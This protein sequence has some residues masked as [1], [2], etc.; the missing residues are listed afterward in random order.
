[1]IRTKASCLVVV[2]T[3]LFAAV[4]C[5]SEQA[6][7][8]LDEGFQEQFDRKA[9]KM[10][11]VFKKLDAAFTASGERSLSQLQTFQNT[12]V[13]KY[14]Q[15]HQPKELVFFTEDAKVVKR[16]ERAVAA[17]KGAPVLKGA[18]PAEITSDFLGEQT[19]ERR[20]L[21]LLWKLSLDGS[22]VRYA[23]LNDGLLYIVTKRNMIFCIN[24]DTGLTQ[25]VYDLKSRPDGAPGFN[26]L[27]VII[28]AGDTIRIIEKATGMD[29][30]R[31]ETDVQ[32]SSRPY[33]GERTYAF[34]CW[35][36]DVCGFSIGDRFP[37]W[38]LKT[39]NH[40]F[41]AP[42]VYGGFA[43]AATDKG[44]FIRYNNVVKLRSS[45]T[46][47]GGRP[48]GDLAGTKDLVFVGSENFEMVAYKVTD[49][50]KAWA[51]SCSG[52]VAR[53][54]WL[55]LDKE[56]LFYSARKDGLYALTTITGKQRWRLAGGLN[57]IA[58]SGNDIY[59]RKADGAVCKVNAK[60]GKVLWSESA[61]PFVEAVSQVD[62]D[63][64]C[65]ISQ[66]GQIFALKPKK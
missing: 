46:D 39:S 63:V 32:P 61:K 35:N 49:G 62:T 50:R 42:I 58:V 19:L 21:S 11:A 38:R 13:S 1:M 30:W 48:V 5:A 23:D 29:K 22:A 2:L 43:F 12:L 55:S 56:V 60:T 20:G 37:R 8:M 17:A 36:G 54:P 18:P 33:C 25:W 51:H 34:G 40:V 64:M 26:S 41:G 53:G 31:F 3:V 4:G 59:V 14:E 6:A 57:P 15:H 28:C 52:R 44:S 9:K 65:L 7:K 27:Y 10:D 24:A 16:S 66:D 45:E 47:L